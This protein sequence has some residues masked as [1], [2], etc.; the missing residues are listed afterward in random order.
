MKAEVSR[1]KS[2]S[3]SS[4]TPRDCQLLKYSRIFEL[5]GVS[6]IEDKYDV[7]F[8]SNQSYYT[9]LDEAK[10]SWKKTQKSNQKKNDELVKTKKIEIEKVLAENRGRDRSWK[11]CGVYD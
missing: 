4:A 1:V 6:D 8:K 2:I 11:T 5:T 7:R 9:L 10:V 3:K